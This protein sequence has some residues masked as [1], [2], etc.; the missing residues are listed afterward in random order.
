MSQWM[1]SP[2]LRTT[3][4]ENDEGAI[5]IGAI[6]NVHA[7]TVFASG[8]CGGGWWKRERGGG[9]G[10]AEA[11]EVVGKPAYLSI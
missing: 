1:A 8:E 4:G 10:G 5:T 3:S 11:E 6:A 2:N 9:R 7:L